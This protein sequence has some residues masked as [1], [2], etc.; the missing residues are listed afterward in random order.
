M[1]TTVTIDDR[2]LKQAKVAAARSGRS[3]S[4]L[5]EDGLRLVVRA[6]APR[7]R[8]RVAL[9]TYGGSGLRPGVELE[10]KDA[11]AALLGDEAAPGAAR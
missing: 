10:D 6:D 5:V 4:E 11:L 1:R 9:P 2:L 7:T 3:L 8:E